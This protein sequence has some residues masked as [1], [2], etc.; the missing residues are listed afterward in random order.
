MRKARVSV[1]GREFH[2]DVIL[3]CY[4]GDTVLPAQEEALTKFL[5][6]DA[7][8]NKAKDAV[9]RYVIS[10]ADD[11]INEVDN[12][13]KYVVPKSIF[14]P[15]ANKKLVALLCNFKLDVEHGLALIFEGGA[16]K[17]I[18]PEDIIL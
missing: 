3:Q 17:E 16:L 15:K 6:T 2:L 14:V 5:E 8:I 18:G 12:I 10:C 11:S 7:T 9:E 4:P 13:F 1:W